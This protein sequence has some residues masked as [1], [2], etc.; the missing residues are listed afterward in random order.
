MEEVEKMDLISVWGWY[1]EWNVML[2]QTFGV[3]LR[4]V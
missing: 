3:F 2:L 4:M 1:V